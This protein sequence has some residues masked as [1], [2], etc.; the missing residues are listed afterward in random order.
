MTQPTDRKSSVLF[1]C[2]GNTAR[3]QMAQALLEHRAPGR[4]VVT[5]AGL[6]PG[7]LNP[8]T[9]KALQEVGLPTDHLQSKGVKPML[10]QHF[11][12]LVTVCDRAEKNCPIF[13]GVTYRLAW[14]FDD[15]AAATGTEEEK[16]EVFRR[17]RGEI[18]RKIQDWLASRPAGEPA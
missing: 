11:T 3:S 4:F 16:L 8:L 13:P 1:L 18:D 6:E 17:V 7:T 10:G 2:T 9:V 15:P 5:S 12:Y 14:P